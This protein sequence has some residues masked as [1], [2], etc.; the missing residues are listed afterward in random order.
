MLQKNRPR[1]PRVAWIGKRLCALVYLCQHLT[2]VA[3]AAVAMHGRQPL[4]LL[5]LR[6]NSRAMRL[7]SATAVVVAKLGVHCPVCWD[8]KATRNEMLPATV[9][10][11]LFFAFVVRHGQNH[12]KSKQL[13]CCASWEDA[14]S[15][16]ARNNTECK[17]YWQRTIE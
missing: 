2:A 15:D 13:V 4:S 10:L 3:A 9:S 1:R 7:S 16:T 14:D 6:N 11:L 12:R 8:R 17:S 5:V